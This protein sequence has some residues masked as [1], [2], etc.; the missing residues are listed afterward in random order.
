MF[1]DNSTFLPWLKYADLTFSSHLLL[2]VAMVVSKKVPA[3]AIVVFII[4]FL[5][6]QF[7]ILIHPV[8]GRIIKRA[9]YALLSVSWLPIALNIPRS[10]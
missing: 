2:G 9:S 6:T 5:L 1:Y 8:Y 4:A 10:K 7:G 3:W